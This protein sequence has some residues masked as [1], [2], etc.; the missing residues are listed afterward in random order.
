MLGEIL[1]E[2]IKYILFPDKQF[3]YLIKTQQL[4]SSII[5]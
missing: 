5:L 4:L 1:L 3:K 2:N